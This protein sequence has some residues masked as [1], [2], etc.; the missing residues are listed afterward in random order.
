MVYYIWRFVSHPNKPK[1]LPKARSRDPKLERKLKDLLDKKVIEPS[2]GEPAFIS[3]IK[4]VPKANGEDRLILDLSKL[5]KFICPMSFKMPKLSDL[6]AVLPEKA[7]LA[8][9]DLRDA[10]HHVPIHKDFRKYL[11]F[12]WGEKLFQFSALPFGLSIAPAIFTGMSNPAHAELRRLGISAIVYLDDWLF[13][14]ESRKGCE[15]AIKNGIS[16]LERMGWLINYE[17]SQIQMFQNG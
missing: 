14:H 3:N 11:T 12:L 6:R 2:L 13:W 15:I 7:W 8:K 1:N 16:T 17:K 4:L 5:N 9:L 10:Y